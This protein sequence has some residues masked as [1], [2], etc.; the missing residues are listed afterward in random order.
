MEAI[1]ENVLNVT[2]L[3]PRVK[4]PT[5]FARFDELNE[6]ESLTILNDH[7]PKPLYY[8]LMGERGDIFTWE[9][10]ENGPQWWRIKISKKVMGEGKET[11]GEIVAKDLRAAQVFKKFG[12]D[13]CCDGNKTMK[14]ACATKGLEVA[15]VEKELQQLDKVQ[16]A[17][18]LPFNDWGLDFLSDYI[19]NTHHSYL[20]KNLPDLRAYASKVF[21]VHGGRHPELE[22][23]HQLVEATSAELTSHM[24]EEEQTVFP[25]IKKL[26]AAKNGTQQF[27]KGTFGNVL[28]PIETMIKEHEV[29]GNNLHELRKC[30]N[31]YALP[32][33]ACASYS[34]LFRMLD[35]LEDDVHTHIHL[36]NNILFPKAIEMD[37][38]LSKN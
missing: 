30:T 12:L 1:A 32:D 16:S 9:Y 23:V 35:E 2:E 36:E 38:L 6:G 11:L 28:A 3:E 24:Q 25:Y 34:L 19:V 37:K 5:I 18:P 21:K 14:E 20:R 33:D 27:E 15:V 29:V 4:H 26:V 10:L 22:K 7:D 17:R 31:G 13:F 8:Q